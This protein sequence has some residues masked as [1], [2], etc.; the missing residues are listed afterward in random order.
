VELVVEGEVNLWRSVRGL[1]YG[2]GIL[3]KQLCTYIRERRTH[4]LC[5]TG[6]GRYIKEAL[7][8]ETIQFTASTGPAPAALL[9]LKPVTYQHKNEQELA[10]KSHGTSVI[11]SAVQTVTLTSL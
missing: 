4:C 1:K 3:L 7:G 9:G 5:D 10:G 6:H 8:Q 11:T 2:I